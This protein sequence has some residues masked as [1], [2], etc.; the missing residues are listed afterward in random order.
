LSLKTHLMLA[1]CTCRTRPDLS[2]RTLTP[3]LPNACCCARPACPSQTGD[4]K[5]LVAGSVGPSC[6]VAFSVEATPACDAAA[7]GKVKCSKVTL[8]LQAGACNGVKLKKT[9]LYSGGGDDPTIS[10][11][12]AN[13]VFAPGA[14]SRPRSRRAPALAAV[15]ISVCRTLLLNRRRVCEAPP[16]CPVPRPRPVQVRS[17]P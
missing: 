17:H 5:F 16:A 4:Y 10:N 6:T 11:L 13:K 3:R 15:M 2:D 9:D 7:A 1:V 12:P 14:A 8:T